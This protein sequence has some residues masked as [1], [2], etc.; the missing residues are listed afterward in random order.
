MA[1]SFSKGLSSAS[2]ILPLPTNS[3]DCFKYDIDRPRARA[4]VP[5]VGRE[6]PVEEAEQGRLAGA[7][8]PDEPD[9]IAGIHLPG[10]AGED[11]GARISEMCVG[12][13]Y[14]HARF[15]STSY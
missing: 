1:S 4:T 12:E 7:V 8:G 15:S 5:R 14:Q 2:K 10:Q 9:A 3:C 13:L 11:V 6:A